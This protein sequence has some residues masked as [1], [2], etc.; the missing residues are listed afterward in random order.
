[1]SQSK[2]LTF[3]ELVVGDHFIAFP[4]DGDDA[5]HGGYRGAQNL[6]K[7]IRDMR[8]QSASDALVQNAV[9]TTSGVLSCMPASMPVLKINV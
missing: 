3:V 5:G 2:P 6:F 1:M 4:T 9:A 7:K 8:S